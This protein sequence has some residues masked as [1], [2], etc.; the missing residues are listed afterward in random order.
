MNIKEV[1]VNLASRI[2]QFRV[3]MYDR[4]GLIHELMGFIHGINS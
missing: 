3:H 1:R 4:R 2:S